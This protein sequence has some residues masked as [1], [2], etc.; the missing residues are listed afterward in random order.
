MEVKE[1]RDAIIQNTALGKN[2]VNK[3]KQVKQAEYYCTNCK[4]NNSVM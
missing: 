4:S 2:K 3:L 1:L